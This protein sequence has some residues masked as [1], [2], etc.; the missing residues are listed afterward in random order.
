MKRIKKEVEVLK[1]DVIKDMTA[2]RLDRSGAI[3]PTQM[4]SRSI[5]RSPPNRQIVGDFSYGFTAV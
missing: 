2:S 3:S 4:T 1:D 5:V